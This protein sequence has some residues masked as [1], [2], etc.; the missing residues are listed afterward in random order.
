MRIVIFFRILFLLLPSLSL[1]QACKTGQ[2]KG[3][4][5]ISS[6]EKFR[7]SILA[8]NR[9]LAPDTS[10]IFDDNTSFTPGI[11][12]LNALLI[13]IGTLLHREISVMKKMDTLI[14]RFKNVE[15]YSQE[16]KENLKENLKM[17]DSFLTANKP[18]KKITCRGK[19]CYLYVEVIKSRQLLY[20]YLGR[21]LKDSFPVSTG[22]KK[23]ATP[24]LNI[25]PTG[26]LFTKYTSRK[27]PGGNYKGL[28]NMPYAV[29]IKGGYAIHGTTPGNFSKLGTVASHGCIRL[30][31]DNARVFY[32]LVNLVGLADTWV[33]VRDSL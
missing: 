19:E 21:V 25:R 5:K 31:P 24:D 29:F 3:K 18:E 14:K 10:N 20:L 33:N 22:I 9:L 7:D 13:R 30:H 16:E 26:P 6:Y 15:S 11:D 4:E 12:S 8:E 32:E 2:G 17:L 1:F 28:G 23:Y 27:W